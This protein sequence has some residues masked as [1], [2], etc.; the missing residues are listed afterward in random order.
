MEV[1]FCEL[2]WPDALPFTKATA[3]KHW[4]TKSQTKQCWLLPKN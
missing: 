1:N 2:L 4:R 3:A